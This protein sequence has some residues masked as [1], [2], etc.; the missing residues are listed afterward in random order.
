MIILRLSRELNE[1]PI[2]DETLGPGLVD[3]CL[4]TYLAI[5]QFLPQT[6]QQGAVN[7]IDSTCYPFMQLSYTTW[8][9]GTKTSVLCKRRSFRITRKGYHML[10]ITL[11]YHVDKSEAG[12]GL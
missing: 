8:Q 3:P 7:V 6:D 1:A 2:E 9:R 10:S 11:V 12:T 4:K 5:V